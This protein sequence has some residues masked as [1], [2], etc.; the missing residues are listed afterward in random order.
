MMVLG[1]ASLTTISNPV[2]YS[3]RSVRSSTTES[4]AMRRSS[5]LLTAK[6][7]GQAEIPLD[8]MPRT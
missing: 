2:R 6:C 3:S 7:L 8:W 1:F 5:W 4:D